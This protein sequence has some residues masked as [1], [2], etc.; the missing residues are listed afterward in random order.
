MCVAHTTTGNEI[1]I[2]SNKDCSV[3]LYTATDG[4]NFDEDDITCLLNG[5]FTSVY[6]VPERGIGRY[7]MVER[8]SGR[9]LPTFMKIK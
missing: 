9:I 3:A 2:C 1:L 6:E 4:I 7:Q 8:P 5:Q